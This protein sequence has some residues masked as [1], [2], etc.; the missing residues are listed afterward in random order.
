MADRAPSTV[1]VGREAE[2][3]ELEAVVRRAAV[4]GSAGMI[5]TGE[6]GV[7]KTVLC[8]AAFG[9]PEWATA[10]VVTC[11]PLQALS[12]GLAPLRTALRASSAPAAP[13]AAC[14]ARIDAGDP[15]RAVDDWVQEVVVDRPLVVMV[16][17]L[18]WADDSLRDLVLYLLAGPPDRRLAVLVTARTAGL[19]DGDPF[20]R[21]LA[22]ALHL[23]G[24]AR[25]EVGPLDRPGTEAL[26]ADLVGGRPHQSLVEEVYR[27]GRGNPYLTSLLARNWRRRTGTYPTSCPAIWSPP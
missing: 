21:W 6:A 5:I 4:G 16:D 9:S 27:A 10:L 11:L 23:P 1:L 26:L 22:D 12:T 25:L 15:V 2:L 17:D 13:T 14:L 8:R 18:Q 7:G 24:V 20:H 3:A 19:P